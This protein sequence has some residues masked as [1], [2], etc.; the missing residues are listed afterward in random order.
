MF[1][2][3]CLEP[4]PHVANG[5]P[6]P[7]RDSPPAHPGCCPS[8][9]CDQG[10]GLDQPPP[11]LAE[12]LFPQETKGMQREMENEGKL[13]CL[14]ENLQNPRRHQRSGWSPNSWPPRHPTILVLSFQIIS[15][16][17][18]LFSNT[19]L[20]RSLASGNSSGAGRTALMRAGVAGGPGGSF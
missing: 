15:H 1:C 10:A 12:F 11:S 13:G 3:H 4:R 16:R 20:G 5:S 8:E 17:P 19:I 6:P 7:M 2:L 18:I 9:G 14:L